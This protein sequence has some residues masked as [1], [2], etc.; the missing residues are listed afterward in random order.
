ML[1][2]SKEVIL[3]KNLGWYAEKKNPIQNHMNMKF[4]L[5]EKAWNKY[6]DDLRYK[7]VRTNQTKKW[8]SPSIFF[9]NEY[10]RFSDYPN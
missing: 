7:K 2:C 4:N 6:Y 10:N 1:H 3:E 8:F 5:L 9:F